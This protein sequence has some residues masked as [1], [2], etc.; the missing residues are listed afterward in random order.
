MKPEITEQQLAQL[1]AENSNFLAL[2]KYL[3]A[4]NGGQ[5]II[6]TKDLSDIAENQGLSITPGDKNFVPTPENPNPATIVV[7]V[8][9][10]EETEQIN[11]KLK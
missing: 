5:V 10:K 2:T 1:I 11:Q 7:R 8:H 4:I 6:N 3:T 9:S